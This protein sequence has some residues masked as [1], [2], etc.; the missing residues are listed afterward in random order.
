MSR[1]NVIVIV[2]TTLYRKGGHQFPVVAE[3]LAK[4]KKAAGFDSKI[5]TQAVESKREVL[6]IFDDL[7]QQVFEKIGVFL[8][9]TR[10]H[11]KLPGAARTVLDRVEQMRLARSL[12]A[13]DRHHFGVRSQRLP[14]E[15]DDA[16]K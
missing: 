14:V 13:K 9:R 7:K 11:Q 2:Y 16:Q 1:N 12:V 8:I 6:H 5:I 4:E 3:T 10:R 15:I